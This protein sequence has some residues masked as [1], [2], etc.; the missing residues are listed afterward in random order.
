[1]KKETIYSQSLLRCSKYMFVINNTLLKVQLYSWNYDFI[2]L[3][4]P[5]QSFIKMKS[6]QKKNIFM[7]SSVPKKCSCFNHQSRIIYILYYM[8]FHS[9]D[10]NKSHRCRQQ[11]S[12]QFS[13]AI[14]LKEILHERSKN[15]PCTVY[16]FFA[17]MRFK[18]PLSFMTESINKS[19]L[20][21]QKDW[22]GNL[23]DILDY[24]IYY[25]FSKIVI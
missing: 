19:S 16:S 6:L 9:S 15:T 22:L 24:H 1:M 23:G 7:T 17:I 4:I 18:R 21:F 3:S 25:I 11:N 10:V 13:T 20:Y 14:Y 8:V 2:S 12:L 5:V